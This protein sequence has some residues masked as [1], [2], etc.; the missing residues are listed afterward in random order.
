MDLRRYIRSRLLGSHKPGVV[1][2]QQGQKTVPGEF[3]PPTAAVRPKPAAPTPG[4]AQGQRLPG[5]HG[6]QRRIHGRQPGHE[7]AR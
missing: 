4:Q 1:A 7:A 6:P 2:L 5:Q 3:R